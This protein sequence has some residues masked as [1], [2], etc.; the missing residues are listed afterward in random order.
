MKTG[1]V[2]WD[3]VLA[4]YKIGYSATMA[5]LVVK[6][7]VIVGISGGDYPTRGFLDAYDPADRQ[8]RL[9]LLH[10]AG[11][12]RAGQRDMA[13][14]AGRAGARR[15]RHVGHRQRTIRS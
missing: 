3:V 11:T 2:L 5:P 1:S 13:G 9:A 14:V 6:D 4:D 10:R 15:R 12:G 7:K 8:A